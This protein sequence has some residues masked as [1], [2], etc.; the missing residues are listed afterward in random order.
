MSRTN[1]DEWMVIVNPNAGSGR[2][3]KDWGSISALLAK[4]SISYKSVFTECPKHAIQL[5]HD[6]ILEGYRSF[7]VVGG[8]GTLNEVVNGAFSQSVC[9]GGNCT[10]HDCGWHR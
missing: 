9:P 3:K 4:Y 1:T 5:T 10:G 2:G 8:D 6:S 7:I